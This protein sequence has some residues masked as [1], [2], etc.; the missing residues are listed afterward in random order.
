MQLRQCILFTAEEDRFRFA[1]QGYID[2]HVGEF[3]FTERI[4]ARIAK[5]RCH[6]VVAHIVDER[7]MCFQ[8]A[9]AA[10]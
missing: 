3:L 4:E 2:E 8:T 6:C 7:A 5:G 1:E 9:D 10:A